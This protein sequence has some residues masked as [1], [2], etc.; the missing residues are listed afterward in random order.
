MPSGTA[1]HLSAGINRVVE[2]YQWGRKTV[3]TVLMDNKFEP[4]PTSVPNLVVNTTVAKK[5]VPE[6][7]L[8]ICL[9][10]K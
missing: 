3:G 4:L 1:K 10:N 6:I 5:H 9:I 8:R 2:L 7:E